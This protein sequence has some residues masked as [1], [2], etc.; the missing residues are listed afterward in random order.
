[1][2]QAVVCLYQSQ[3]GVGVVMRVAKKTLSFAVPH[4]PHAALIAEHCT[5]PVHV[6]VPGTIPGHVSVQE[7]TSRSAE[8]AVMHTNALGQR[9]AVTVPESDLASYGDLL[10]SYQQQQLR[11]QCRQSHCY[12]IVT[13]DCLCRA[14]LT[15][16]QLC[17]S[18]LKVCLKLPPQTKTEQV[19]MVTAGC[20]TMTWRVI[21]SGPGC[22]S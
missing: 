16:V 17:T 20:R 3:R 7:N 14:N 2:T 5:I 4:A 11:V 12:G 22:P 1:M 13:A 10:V 21:T 19:K 9:T 6:G 15:L 8:D 18:S